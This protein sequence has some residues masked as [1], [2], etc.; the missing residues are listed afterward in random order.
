MNSLRNR[1]ILI[2]RLGAKPETKTLANG[3]L[4]ARFSIA[5]TETYKNEQGQRINE[6]HWHDLVAWGKAA[7][8]AAR[9]LEKGK[10]I[11]I[12]GKL[13]TRQY[14]DKEGHKQYIT[15]VVVHD[16]LMIG[17]KAF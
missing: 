13:L 4:M 15:E 2:G 14:L 11:A 7:D 5:I 12:E 17:S 6:T 1:V 9:F 10:E 3:C 16:M 8:I